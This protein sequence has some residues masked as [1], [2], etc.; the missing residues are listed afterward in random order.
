MLNATQP[1]DLLER[2]GEGLFALDSEWRFSYLN[3]QAERVLARLSGVPSSDLLGT[4]FTKEFLGL[5]CAAMLLKQI[6]S[7]NNL[8]EAGRYLAVK[9]SRHARWAG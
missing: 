4:I 9:D 3:R 8:F 6:T 7:T 2:V 1:L 5:W